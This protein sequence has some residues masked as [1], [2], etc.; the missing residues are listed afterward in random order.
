VYFLIGLQ[1]TAGKFFLFMIFIILCSVTS[2]SLAL[3]V[4]ALCRTTA[5]SVTVLPMVLELARLF[6]G[7]FIAPSRLPKY[8]TWLTALSYINY[9]FIGSALNELQGLK[10]TC[11]GA[12]T[13][14]VNATYTITAACINNGEALIQDRGYNYIDIGG[15]IGVLI[16]FIIFC[17][18][19]AFLGV[20]FLKH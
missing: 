2:T 16:G 18:A 14:V 11:D 15:C 17:R 8:F 3:M 6:G 20:R 7:F 13:T 5:L 4:S 10:L 9:S 12:K 1:A 19:C